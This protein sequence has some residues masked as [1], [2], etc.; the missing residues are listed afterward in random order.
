MQYVNSNTTN[1]AGKL[2]HM[3]INDLNEWW[4]KPIID[5]DFENTV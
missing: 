4:N 1:A 3:F 5:F 2:F